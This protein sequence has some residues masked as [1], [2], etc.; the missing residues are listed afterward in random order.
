MQP[1]DFIALSIVGVLTVLTLTGHN[2]NV[3]EVVALILGYY[4]AKR[5]INCRKSLA[6]TASITAIMALT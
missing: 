1:K 2:G 3:N 5:L 6:S 4:F